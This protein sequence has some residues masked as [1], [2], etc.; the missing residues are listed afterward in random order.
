MKIFTEEKEL[1]YQVQINYKSGCSVVNWFRK[2]DF[3]KSEG[4]TSVKWEETL[5]YSS[6]CFLKAIENEKKDVDIVADVQHLFAKEIVMIGVDDIES[7]VSLQTRIVNIISGEFLG[8][9]EGKLKNVKG[10]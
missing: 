5:D 9:I 10:Y 1:I 4:K 6:Y 7:I 3:T 8:I 2:F